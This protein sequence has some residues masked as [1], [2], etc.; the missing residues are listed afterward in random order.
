MIELRTLGYFATACRCDTLARAA[1]ELGIA[2]STLSSALKSLEEELG[3]PLFRRVNH[4]LYPTAGAR[5]LMRIAE[6]LLDS[7]AVRQAMDWDAAGA[8]CSAADG[9]IGA[10]LHHRRYRR[11]P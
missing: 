2:Q 11:R 8:S 1:N 5:W 9:R 10:E 3:V 4:G 6:P 7:E